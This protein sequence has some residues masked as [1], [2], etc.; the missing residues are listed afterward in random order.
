MQHFLCYCFPE[1]LSSSTKKEIFCSGTNTSY[2]DWIIND[3]EPFIK[4]ENKPIITNFLWLSYFYFFYSLIFQFLIS[5]L[6]EGRLYSNLKIYTFFYYCFNSVV[7][8]LTLVVHKSEI[9]LSRLFLRL[10]IKII[11]TMICHRI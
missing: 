5:I 4:H 9:T 2:L 7:L 8:K 11:S 6:P 10:W 1:Q 3:G